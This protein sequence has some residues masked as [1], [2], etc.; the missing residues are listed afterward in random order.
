MTEQFK[1]YRETLSK[2]RWIS[3][4]AALLM[5]TLALLSLF[6]LFRFFY[7]NPSDS[8]SFYES[9]LLRAAVFLQ[10]ATALIFAARFAL[11]FK[12]SEEMFI[13]A[14]ILW[15]CGLFLLLF[16]WYISLPVPGPFSIYDTIGSSFFVFASRSF[17]FFAILYL[18]FSPALK[19]VAVAI[20]FFRS[21]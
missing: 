10:F 1:K 18:I 4:I 17:D 20:A 14:K 7:V 12:R 19:L 6:D 13:R 5:A 11:L 9:P 15:F 2:I 16:Y 8:G 3:K 21:R